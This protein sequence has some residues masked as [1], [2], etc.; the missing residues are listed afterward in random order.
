MKQR[1]NL[2]CKH[3][4]EKP[5][6]FTHLTFKVK[7]NDQVR[8]AD[9]HT[10]HTFVKLRQTGT[11]AVD[12]NLCTPQAHF[13]CPGVNSVQLVR[14]K[15]KQSNSFLQTRIPNWSQTDGR[16]EGLSAPPVQALI[17]QIFLSPPPPHPS[18]RRCSLLSC[19]RKHCSIRLNRQLNTL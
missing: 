9:C 17:L 4:F 15:K 8:L 6:H 18:I 13:Q 16:T 12:R 10:Q 2:K 5:P 7:M 19:T 1:C 3:F 14:P 11:I